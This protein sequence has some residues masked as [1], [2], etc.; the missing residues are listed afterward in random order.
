MFCYCNG[1][2][3]NGAAAQLAKLMSRLTIYHGDAIE[4]LAKP[5]KVDRIYLDPMFPA[6]SYKSAVNKHMQ[7]LHTVTTP[8]SIAQSQQLLSAAALARIT[9]QGMVVVKRP[10]LAPF[11]CRSIA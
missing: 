3:K 6:D 5:P 7:M 9:P 8:P 1:T 11:L 10:K 2:A 4:L